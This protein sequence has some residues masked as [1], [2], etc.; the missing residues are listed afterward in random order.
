MSGPSVQRVALDGTVHVTD[1]TP[2][3]LYLLGVPI[4]N[5]LDGKVL[6]RFIHPE[7]VKTHPMLTGPASSILTSSVMTRGEQE[8]VEERLRRLGYV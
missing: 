2:T 8:Q 5:D 1:I 6:T 3:V 7:Y 4:P